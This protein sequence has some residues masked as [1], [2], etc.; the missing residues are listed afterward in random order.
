M[1][2]RIFNRRGSAF[3]EGIIVTCV[4]VAFI[5]TMLL[6]PPVYA[7]RENLDYMARKMVRAVEVTGKIDSSITTLADEL[8]EELGLD[9]TIEWDV[10]YIP[11]TN[12][13]QLRDTFTLTLKANYP[14][15]LFEPQ[16][17]TP[18]KV[19][20]PLTVTL[21]GVSEVYFK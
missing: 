9:P 2:K 15:T 13:I 20:I 6:L 19:N 14:V 5:S 18:T 7:V 16:W 1:K 3:V 12:K 4:L 21:T 17:G 10:D 11:G 8:G